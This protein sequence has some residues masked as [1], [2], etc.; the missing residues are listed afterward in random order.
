MP[1]LDFPYP[2][3]HWPI[4]IPNYEDKM[5]LDSDDIFEIVNQHTKQLMQ[6]ASQMGAVRSEVEHLR[7]KIVK[8]MTT[9]SPD[10]VPR[11]DFL[12]E[13]TNDFGIIQKCLELKK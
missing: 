13:I 6:L 10:A 1:Y 2:V 5:D 3:E 11:P 12:R 8:Y 9:L 4:P 7:E